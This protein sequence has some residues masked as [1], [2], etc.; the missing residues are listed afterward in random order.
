MNELQKP[1]DKI[2]ISLSILCVVHCFATPILI[3]LLPAFASLPLE[4]ESLH[5]WMV[6]GV[7]P[8]SL[9][10]LTL[11]CKKHRK[12]QVLITGGAGLALVVIAISGEA[13]GFGEEMEKALTLVGSSL[14]ALAHVWNYRLCQRD[15]CE[16]H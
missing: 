11:G 2:A 1:A 13:I 6:I 16:C 3:T 10:S 12:P 14:I 8:V 5:F 7:L 9:F 4:G 15:A